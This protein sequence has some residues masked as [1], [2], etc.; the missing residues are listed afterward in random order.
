MR[1]DENFVKRFSWSASV[2]I[3]GTGYMF[4]GSNSKDSPEFSNEIWQFAP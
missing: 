4:W 3:D 1:C 2:A